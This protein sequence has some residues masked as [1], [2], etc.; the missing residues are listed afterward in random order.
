[1]KIAFYNPTHISFFSGPEVWLMNILPLLV[2]KGHEVTLFTTRQQ[3]QLGERAKAIQ[4]LR[5]KGVEVCELFSVP[6]PFSG[7]HIPFL[8]S[9]KIIKKQDY[10]YFFNGY[11]FQDLVV[12]ILS[13]LMRAKLIY[14][15]HAPLYTSNL[16]HNIYQKHLAMRVL[17]KSNQVHVLNKQDL[18]NLQGIHSNIFLI[19]SGVNSNFFDARRYL[20]SKN[21]SDKLKI[22]FLGRLSPQK[23]I[24]KLLRVM[25]KV[26]QNEDRIEFTIAG[27][28]EYRNQVVE[29][30]EKRENVTY[31]SHVSHDDIL[32]LLSSQDIFINLSLYETF[33]TAILEAVAAGCWVM[34]TPTAG[35]ATDYNFSFT[36]LGFDSPE[37]AIASSITDLSVIYF[38]DYFRFA[39]IALSNLEKS[40]AFTW[41]NIVMKLEKSLE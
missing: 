32:T 17:K 13:L 30:A 39:E 23:D 2:E 24:L 28:G 3:K 34:A 5:S 40:K 7:S 37:T 11:A 8:L 16:M 22:I 36:H 12:L 41:E 6:I 33:C 27:D 21:E 38:D 1:M 26:L 25:D 9:P 10:I 18:Y 31:V 20:F 29:F 15:L 35:M 4:T 14:S 19:P